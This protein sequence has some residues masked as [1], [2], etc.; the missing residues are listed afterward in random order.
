MN[1]IRKPLVKSK[2][3]PIRRNQ[4]ELA[5][6]AAWLATQGAEIGI[7]T[8]PYELIRYKAYVDGGRKAV[9]HI[10]YTKD[11]GLLTFM[12]SS[13][14][15]YQAMLGLVVDEPPAPPPKAPQ[16][17]A[18]RSDI[19]LACLREIQNSTHRSLL[20]RDGD[21]CWYCGNP[22]GRDITIEHL[23]PKAHGGPNRMSNYALAHSKCN[24]TAADK[25][26]VDKMALRTRL[27]AK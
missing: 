21:E 17:D 22:L 10:V 9:T 18:I 26:L 3:F 15:H 23:I 2:P 12:G 13:K 24:G 6:F 20:V 4:F 5:R 8:N 1:D 27:R 7:P 16:K 14:R 11:N 19:S 25:S